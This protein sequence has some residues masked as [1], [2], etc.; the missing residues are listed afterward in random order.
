[1]K[2]IRILLSLVFVIVLAPALSAGSASVTATSPAEQTQEV[3]SQQIIHA[4]PQGPQYMAESREVPWGGF[5]VIPALALVF[6][7]P[8]IM[9]TYFSSRVQPVSA[10]P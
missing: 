2:G 3:D 1:M 5:L 7:F 9:V 10:Q 6:L 4:V 8:V